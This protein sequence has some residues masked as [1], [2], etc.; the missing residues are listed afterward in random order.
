MNRLLIRPADCDLETTRTTAALASRGAKVVALRHESPVSLVIDSLRLRSRIAGADL[1]H[2]FGGHALAV[3]IGA[4][5][6]PIVFTP[7]GFPTRALIGWLRA[8][9]SYRRIDVVCT[10]DTARRALVTRGFPFEQTHLI[11]PGVNL[12]S[13]P[14][15]RYRSLRNELG[16]SDDHTVIFC[17]LETTHTSGHAAAMW[18]MSILNVIQPPYRLLFW[19]RG[20]AADHLRDLLERV[21]DP[22]MSRVVDREDPEPLFAAADAVLLTPAGAIPM[23][24]LAMAM[25]SSKPII[26]TVTSQV[27]ELIED[28]HTALLV[29][30]STPRAI[31]HRVV[32]CVSDPTLAW[33]LADRARAEAYD[34][35]TQAKMLELHRQL[36]E[37]VSGA[38][39]TVSSPS[40]AKPSEA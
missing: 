16:F 36:Y 37:S 26:S 13:I 23:Y 15:S 11:R 24:P 32:D 33:K 39:N 3:A 8:I 30:A 6:A 27:C 12:S 9:G 4:S 34:H 31:A 10:S 18:A 35:L 38:A 40:F 1:V 14:T 17:P 7:I 5:T 22:E 28:R 19:S 29:K 21:I 2:A 20:S 25:A